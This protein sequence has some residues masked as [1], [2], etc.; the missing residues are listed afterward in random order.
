MATTYL[1]HGI[2]SKR[3]IL[4]LRVISLGRSTAHVQLLH[5]GGVISRR[6][7][8]MRRGWRFGALESVPPSQ[9]TRWRQRGNQ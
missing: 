4:G 6:Y 3:P 9:H 5:P 2:R 1:Y 8:S 7:I